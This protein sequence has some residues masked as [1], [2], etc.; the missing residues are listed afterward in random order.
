M[1]LPKI[2][3]EK[4]SGYFLKEHN[5][6]EISSN[7]IFN[8]EKKTNAPYNTRYNTRSIFNDCLRRRAGIL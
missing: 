7:Q 6:S 8:L 3:L 4:A 1:S 2:S 5:N